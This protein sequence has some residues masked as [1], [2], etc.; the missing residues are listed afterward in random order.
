MDSAS[1]QRKKASAAMEPVLA[2]LAQEIRTSFD[3]YESRSVS[4]VEKIF[5]S[6]GATLYE[7]FK[8]MLAG[9]LGMDVENWDPLKKSQFRLPLMQQ[10]PIRWQASLLLQ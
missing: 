4:S 3:Y 5:I 10:G 7:G 9:F 1:A 6:G 2:K 8:D